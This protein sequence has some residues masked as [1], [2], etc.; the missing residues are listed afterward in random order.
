[1]GLELAVK[2]IVADVA[3][4]LVVG[5]EVAEE[6]AFEGREGLAA[7]VLLAL[8]GGLGLVHVGAGL[9]V[10]D[11]SAW[12]SPSRGFWGGGSVVAVAFLRFRARVPVRLMENAPVFLDLE[13]MVGG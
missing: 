5:I 11:V 7:L 9:S 13:G 6:V 4:T 2:L 10:V 8:L 12:A 1:M 3:R